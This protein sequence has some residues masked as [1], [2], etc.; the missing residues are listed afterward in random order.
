MLLSV[1]DAAHMPRFTITRNGHTLG[2]IDAF[3]DRIDLGSGSGCQIV[4]DD[5]AIGFR[6]GAIDFVGHSY[7]VTAAYDT[8]INTT[9][10]HIYP[11]LILPDNSLG[12]HEV[13]LV[14]ATSDENDTG[15][16]EPELRAL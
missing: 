12:L 13:D 5:A 11:G 7:G 9:D 16:M 6:N 3:G 15:E 2:Q 10:Q 14:R 1:C 8:T 4:I